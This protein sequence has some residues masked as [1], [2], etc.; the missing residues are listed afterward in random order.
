MTRAAGLVASSLSVSPPNWGRQTVPQDQQAVTFLSLP[1]QVRIF[2]PPSWT[3]L[4][5]PFALPLPAT[6]TVLTSI[7]GHRERIQS[8]SNLVPAQ[9]HGELGPARDSG[10]NRQVPLP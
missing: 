5:L 7:W 6:A 1:N 8:Y 3:S 9:L 4:P 10:G 2:L